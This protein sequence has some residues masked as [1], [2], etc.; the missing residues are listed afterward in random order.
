[1]RELPDPIDISELE[2]AWFAGFF[3]ADG[4]VYLNGSQVVCQVNLQRSDKWVQEEFSKHFGGKFY[5]RE[6]DNTNHWYI[7]N[8]EAVTLLSTLFPYLRIK[9]TEAQVAVSFYERYPTEKSKSEFASNCKDLLT[10]LHYT[11]RDLEPLDIRKEDTRAYLAGLFDGDGCVYIR[12]YKVQ[13]QFLLCIGIASNVSCQ[14][15]TDQLKQIF[16]GIAHHKKNTEAIEWS[17]TSNKGEDFLKVILPYLRLKKKQGELALEFNSKRRQ[18][19]HHGSQEKSILGQ[20]YKDLISKLNQ[21]ECVD[22]SD[23][24]V[25]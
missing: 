2:K 8:T 21:R 22:T 6:Q 3:D 5:S 25:L 12:H 18:L 13:N 17:V 14:K 1:M 9:K 7:T 16:G 23:Y 4:G 15:Q 20:H 11:E 19:P 10:T 24:R